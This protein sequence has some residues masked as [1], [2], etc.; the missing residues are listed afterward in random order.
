[1]LAPI[2]LTHSSHSS[3]NNHNNRN[4]HN[5]H[6]SR[7]S[8]IF[9][10]Q[11]H[12]TPCPCMGSHPKGCLLQVS[13]STRKA[14]AQVY[15]CNSSNSSNSHHSHSHSHSHRNRTVEVV[16]LVERRHLA[17]RNNNCCFVASFCLFCGLSF[18]FSVFLFCVAYLVLCITRTRTQ[19]TD[20]GGWARGK[21]EVEVEGKR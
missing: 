20:R 5:S 4:S 8:S 17:S 18:F 19:Q 11:C 9:L 12:V 7:N 10:A 15:P 13:Q 2:H 21:A 14:Q 16:L 3:R 6:N 1:M